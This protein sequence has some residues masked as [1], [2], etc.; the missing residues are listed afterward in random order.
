MRRPEASPTLLVLA[1]LVA[2]FLLQEL[3]V[4]L[5]GFGAARSLF[6]LS[7]PVG[8]APWTVVTSVFAH[9][10]TSHLLANG[11]GLLFVGLPL[12]RTTTRDRFLA[13]FVLTGVVAGIAEVTVSGTVAGVLSW[14]SALPLVGALFP[15]PPGGVGVLGASGAVFGLLGYLL[16]G[17]PLTDR[18]VAGVDLSPRAQLV[19]F[20]LLAVVLTLATAGPRVALLAHFTGLLV[21]LLAGRVR[22]LSPDDDR[23]ATTA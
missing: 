3:V 1:V 2:V 19:A 21:G 6:V 11:V 22:L 9:S 7:A 23:P 12:E 5:F 13:F 16:T 17:N 15:A 18:V 8:R 4:V 10:S 20:A 14:L